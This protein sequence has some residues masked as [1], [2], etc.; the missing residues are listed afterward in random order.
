MIYLY[1]VAE[2]LNLESFQHGSIQ[3]FPDKF[4][5]P[6]SCHVPHESDNFFS[7]CSCSSYVV[8]GRDLTPIQTEGYPQED[9][10]H[11]TKTISLWYFVSF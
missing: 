10:D 7:V 8:S 1:P 5:I 3:S 6:V 2:S 9:L 11:L 4:I